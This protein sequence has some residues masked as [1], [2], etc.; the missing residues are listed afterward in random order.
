MIEL[1]SNP[2]SLDDAFAGLTF[3][4]DRTPEMWDDDA[5]AAFG[6]VSG[7]RNGGVFVAH[8]AGNSEWERHR[9]GDEIVVVVEGSTRLITLSGGI[10]IKHD[11]AANDVLVVPSGVWHRFET[12]AAGV[13]VI[14]VT[15][16]P[17]DHQIERPES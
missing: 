16:Q 9:N 2:V 5:S 8:Y 3:L 12:P 11:M 4:A 1:A 7:Y 17:T 10:E 14:T 6:V 13:K 15:P